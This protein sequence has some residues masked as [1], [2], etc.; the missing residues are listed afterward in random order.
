MRAFI[1]KGKRVTALVLCAVMMLGLTACGKKEADSAVTEQ[2][3]YVYVPEYMEMENSENANL[4]NL[5]VHGSNI[6]YM[7]YNYDEATGV[8]R[9]AICE[10]SL[11]TGEVK[12]L[13]FAFENERSA[14]SYF[15]DAQGGLCT[16]EYQW[17]ASESGENGT[18]N[19]FLCK[20]DA[21]GNLISEQDITEIV[22]D[23]QDYGYI[24]SFVADGQGR[25]YATADEK[26]F[27]FDAEGNYKGN[28]NTEGSW[29]QGIGT[30]NDG[31][32]YV[33]YYDSTGSSNGY[34]LSEVSFEEK[35][36]A[37]SYK[38]FPNSNGNGIL[39]QNQEGKFITN[40][41]SR[42]YEYDMNSQSYTELFA[43]L[44]SDIN[45]NYVN[46]LGVLSDGKLFAVINDWNTGETELASLTRTKASELP[47]KTQVVFG[48]LY[49][50][51]ALQAA[52]VAFNKQSDSYRISIKSYI[53]TNNWTEDSWQDGISKLNNDIT[54]GSN[55]PDILDLSQLSI[56]QLAAK[57]V[58]ED[59]TPYFEKSSVVRKED[60]MDSI[61]SAYT[62]DGKLVCVPKTFSLST[63]A[64]KTSE[65]GTEMGWTLEEMMAYVKAHPDSMI[66][67]YASKTSMMYMLLS[68]NQD[69]FIDWSTG[70]CSF[71]SEE[72]KNILEFIASFPDEA[73]WEADDRSTPL[74]LQD[75]SV[76]MDTVG[77]YDLNTIQQYEAMFGEP[78]TFI[79]Y[80]NSKG[81]SGCYLT[82]NQMYG[83]ASKSK[84][85]DGAWA[86]IEFFL[87]YKDTM[88]S[89]GLPTNESEMEQLIE[90]KTKVEYILDENGEPMKDENGEPIIANAGGGFG[91]GDWEYTYH[92][93]TR[94]EV[95]TLLNLIEVAQPASNADQ[96]IM[97]IM[98]EEAQAFFQGQKSAQDVAGVIQSRVQVYVNENR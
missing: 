51:Q 20:Y 58:F 84:N 49:D 19:Y 52:A 37:A 6:Y 68:Y 86:F 63:I 61:L 29:I 62:F 9:N 90:E 39:V 69:D 92:I 23:G 70:K 48:T 97:T 71:D 47:K 8:S 28:V 43:W 18:E 38:N 4:Y 57:G 56:G 98:E 35:K 65:V 83:I 75:G 14:Q 95:D 16:V 7:T 78:V 55:C 91:Y 67:D 89:Y 15:V 1:R 21:Q 64:G 26:I 77:I 94:E 93:P 13:P 42:V 50:D 80:P 36:L 54:S 27:L 72:F 5:Q 25:F 22:L 60:Y 85:K 59:L 31:K 33:T 3:N 17:I 81:N 11:E 41:G 74:K 2:E 73:D 76:L 32:V 88:F 87:N 10:Y 96:E 12:E 30:G 46:Y 66:F 82:G 24:N 40:D 79:G 44:D 45:G 53:D 34:I